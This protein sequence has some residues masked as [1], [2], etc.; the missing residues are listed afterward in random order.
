MDEV[1]IT[2]TVISVRHVLRPKKVFI[3]ETDRDLCEV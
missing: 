2:E 1:I 3:I